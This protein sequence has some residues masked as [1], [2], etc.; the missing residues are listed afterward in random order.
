MMRMHYPELPD[1]PCPIHIIHVFSYLYSFIKP[2]ELFMHIAFCK[3]AHSDCMRPE[4]LRQ[5]SPYIHYIH[6]GMVNQVP[7]L[8]LIET[9]CNIEL[10]F[11]E[12]IYCFFKKSF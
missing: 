8:R 11:M 10:S 7:A 2:I 6:S 12:L 5:I 1:L 4:E 3:Y 9:S